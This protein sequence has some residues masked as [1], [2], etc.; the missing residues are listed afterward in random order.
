MTVDST[1]CQHAPGFMLITLLVVI[2]ILIALLLPAM[3]QARE[4]ALRSECRNN[5]KQIGLAL[6]NSLEALTT[7]RLYLVILKSIRNRS[8]TSWERII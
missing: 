1:G 7:C 3:Q 2:A 5:L 6:H 8:K 4:A